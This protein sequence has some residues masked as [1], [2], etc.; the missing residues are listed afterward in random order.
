MV[1]APRFPKKERKE[2]INFQA[3]TLPNWIINKNCKQSHKVFTAHIFTLLFL[4]NHIFTKTFWKFSQNLFRKNTSMQTDIVGQ[5]G[6]YV[7]HVK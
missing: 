5:R 4:F 2:I 7:Q 3:A 6:E 1:E